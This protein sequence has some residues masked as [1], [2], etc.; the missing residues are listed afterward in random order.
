MTLL[1]QEVKLAGVKGQ[2]LAYP[3]DLQIAE[4][5]SYLHILGPKVGIIYIL[6]APGIDAAAL[7]RGQTWDLMQ[8]SVNDWAQRKMLLRVEAWVASKVHKRGQQQR[9]LQ[10]TRLP[11]ILQNCRALC[12]RPHLGNLD[13]LNLCPE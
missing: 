13:V 8:P 9:G 1:L 3:L 6:G 7:R 10:N 2:Q 11:W 4:S 5:S 12:C